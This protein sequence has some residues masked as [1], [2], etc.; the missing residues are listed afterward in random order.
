MRCLLRWEPKSCGK[1]DSRN[2]GCK[3]RSKEPPPGPLRGRPIG[4]RPVHRLVIRTHCPPEVDPLK[5]AQFGRQRGFIQQKGQEVL[6]LRNG[7]PPL[8]GDLLRL[9]CMVA[10]EYDDQLSF[11]Q[12]FGNG[13]P[14]SLSG[15][16]AIRILEH[17]GLV[18]AQQLHDRG[19]QRNVGMAVGYENSGALVFHP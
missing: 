15:P 12:R 16:D 10:P 11:V 9:S 6:V 8:I 17:Q 1:N 19:N 4:S 7:Q 13:I 18:C 3:S 2:N 5:F 14:P